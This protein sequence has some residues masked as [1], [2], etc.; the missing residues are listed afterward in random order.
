MGWD[1]QPKGMIPTWLLWVYP[2]PQ[3]SPGAAPGR[4]PH[5]DAP[6]PPPWC[7]SWQILGLPHPK[8]GGSVI[9]TVGC[10]F[11]GERMATLAKWKSKIA[12]LIWGFA[13][14]LGVGQCL[15]MLPL[16]KGIIDEI[17]TLQANQCL[18]RLWDSEKGPVNP[19][20]IQ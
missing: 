1:E 15:W 3:P 11:T 2:T 16:Q 18:S 20:T 17:Y 4:I 14:G 13:Q 19:F 8:K 5:L 6:V 7:F 12:S 9:F 10:Q